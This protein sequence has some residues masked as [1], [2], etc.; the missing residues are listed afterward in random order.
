MVLFL[1]EPSTKSTVG[2]F[3]NGNLMLKNVSLLSSRLV[4]ETGL[5]LLVLVVVDEHHLH[6]VAYIPVDDQIS[7]NA[8]LHHRR[9]VSKIS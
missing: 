2:Q 6:P 9:E 3:Q 4:T 7:W 5:E 1:V 8:I